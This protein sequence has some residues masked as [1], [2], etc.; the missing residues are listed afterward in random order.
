MASAQTLCCPRKSV[1]RAPT[2]HGAGHGAGGRGCGRP[3]R[4][5][6]RLELQSANAAVL[7]RGGSEGGREAG[8]ERERER[9]GERESTIER[10]RDRERERERACEQECERLAGCGRGLQLSEGEEQREGRMGGKDGRGQTH[11]GHRVEH[12]SGMPIHP[13]LTSWNRCPNLGFCRLGG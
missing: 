10:E 7:G 4:R 13:L 3:G 8:T 12:H 6:R 5:G 2:G 11:L 9:G 1:S